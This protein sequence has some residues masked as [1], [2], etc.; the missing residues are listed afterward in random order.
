MYRVLKDKGNNMN[1]TLENMETKA[2]V[3]I[4]RGTM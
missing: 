1:V 3:I 2:S 4:G